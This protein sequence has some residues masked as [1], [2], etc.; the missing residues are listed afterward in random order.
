MTFDYVV[1]GGGTAGCV[2]A[3]RLSENPSCKVLLLE[4]AITWNVS[5]AVKSLLVVML[6]PFQAFPSYS[7]ASVGSVGSVSPPVRPPDPKCVCA[8][9]K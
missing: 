2:L 7:L 6:R 8:L 9:L 4:A 1:V 3:S 5:K